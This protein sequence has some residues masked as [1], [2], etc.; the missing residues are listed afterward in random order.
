MSGRSLRKMILL[1]V[2]A[3]V[4]LMTSIS[5]ADDFRLESA[6]LPAPI[7]EAG[8]PN[9]IIEASGAEPI[10]SG[11][12]FLVAHDKHPSLFVID[13]AT[14]SIV[15]PPMTTAKF[16]EPNATGPKWEG[17]ARDRDG[18]YYLVGAHNGKT[19]VERATK[20]FLY[21]FQLKDVEGDSPSIDGTSVVRFD[22]SK[23]L[24]AA[25]KSQGQDDVALSKR[26]IEG[27][28]I[29]E[30][31]GRRE[32]I[33]GLRQAGG[34]VRAYVADITQTSPGDELD[35]K[36]LFV[37]QS[38]SREG[39]DSELTTLEYVPSLGGFLVGTASED[40]DNAFHGNTLYF[41]ADGSSNQ[42]TKIATFEVAMKLEGLAVLSEVKSEN[43]TVVRLLLTY[44]NDPH[45]T[46]IPSRFQTV[47]L[48]RESR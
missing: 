3:V 41:V 26:K 25:M 8:K 23:S 20:S 16:P 4:T 35:L 12:L 14:G 29:R 39:N 46:K 43:K 7:M 37:F 38:D 11:R 24:V 47:N 19:E 28:A 21:R 34:K 9:V 1:P 2:A 44:D 6:T 40:S 31:N 10:G 45:S 33:V 15:G 48:I 27:L 22:I 13:L 5:A 30:T 18:N 32:L 42:A 36:P 17:M